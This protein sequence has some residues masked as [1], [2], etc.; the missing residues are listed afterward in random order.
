MHATA[1]TY[2][3]VI[4]EINLLRWQL[5]IRTLQIVKGCHPMGLIVAHTYGI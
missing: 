5:S 1:N 3:Q 2:G 4:F